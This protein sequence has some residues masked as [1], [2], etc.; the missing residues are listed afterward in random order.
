M[1]IELPKSNKKPYS[2]RLEQPLMDKVYS[3]C[4]NEE[5]TAPAYISNLI[6]TDLEDKQV[7]RQEYNQYCILELPSLDYDE[8]DLSIQ[9]RQNIAKTDLLNESELSTYLKEYEDSN[10]AVLIKPNNR[11]DKWVNGEY[12]SYEAKNIHYGL[13]VYKFEIEPLDFGAKLFIKFIIKNNKKIEAYLI[14][15]LEALDDAEEVDNNDLIEL[16]NHPF[17]DSDVTDFDKYKWT[18]KPKPSKIIQFKRKESTTN[19]NQNT[20]TYYIKK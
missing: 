19:N 14:S 17:K 10:R 15:Y 5:T 20:K 7:F 6:K 16:I 13:S 2:F 1:P 18:Y 4:E 8:I 11:L 12:R 3:Y 9:N